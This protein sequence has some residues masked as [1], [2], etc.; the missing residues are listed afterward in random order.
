MPIAQ[1]GNRSLSYEIHGNG[2]NVVLLHHGF[3]CMKM[4]SAIYPDLVDAGYRVFMYD[5]R[6]YGQSDPGADFD[7][8]YLS[9]TFCRESAEDLAALSDKFDLSPFHIIGQCEGGV[10][11][12]EFAGTYPDRVV[13]VTAAST[14]CFGNQ[15][16]TEFNAA[17]F[18][19]PFEDLAPDL[20]HKLVDWHGEER[21]GL[22][23][24][25]ARTHGGAYGIGNFD[26]RPRLSLVTCPTLVLYP[27]RSALF[28]V[29][30]AVAFYRCLAKGELAV[31]PRCGH[32]SYDHKPE[33][34]K[35]HVVNFINRVSSA[36]DAIPVDF[37]LTCLAPFPTVPDKAE[38]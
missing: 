22:L 9:G 18:P 20:M 8:F 23:Y 33:E 2:P 11:G 14:L 6:G 13:S 37:S 4:W 5:R 36:A 15:T 3:A 26:I 7:K 19:K 12:V 25:M 28:E 34:Y 17:K 32:N 10:I 38:K 21:A 29:E 30:Q 16:M 31:I 1:I 35:R 24:E 27:D